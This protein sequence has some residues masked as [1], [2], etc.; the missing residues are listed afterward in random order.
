MKNVYRL[1]FCLL[2][3]GPIPGIVKAQKCLLKGTIFS[4]DSLPLANA[5][6][7]L[8]NLTGTVYAFAISGQDGRFTIEAT[9]EKPGDYLLMVSH[10]SFQAVEKKILLDANSTAM[11][12]FHFALSPANSELKEVIVKTK[13]P[14]ISVKYDT[15]E[16]DATP[17][18]G[19]EIIKTADL[20][21]NMPGFLVDNKGRISYNGKEV[22]KILI[23]GDDL[24]GDNY[25]LISTNLQAGVIGKVQVLENYENNRLLKGITKSGK[26]AINLKIM[27]QF[28]NTI[29]GNMEAGGSLNKRFITNERL[30]YISPKIKT[31]LFSNANNTGESPEANVQFYYDQDGPAGSQHSELENRQGLVNSGS[32]TVPGLDDKYSKDNNDISSDLMNS[33][34][35]AKSMKIRT[36]FGYS[37]HRLAME[38]QLVNETSLPFMPPWSIATAETVR[39]HTGEWIAQTSLDHDN[40]GGNTGS[41]FISFSGRKDLNN[42]KNIS[43]LAIVDTLTERLHNSIRNFQFSGNETFR[44]RKNNI[45]TAELAISRQSIVQDFMSMTY[46]FVDYFST[47]SLFSL[48]KQQSNRLSGKYNAGLKW[49]GKKG[50]LNYIYGVTLQLRNGNSLN[51]IANTKRDNF[52]DTMVTRPI[53]FE[54]YQLSKYNLYAN[55]Q[56][57]ICKRGLLTTNISTGYGSE[58]ILD[59]QI[60]RS[61]RSFLFQSLVEVNYKLSTFRSLIA[62]YR[63]GNFMP[64]PLNFYGRGILSGNATILDGAM[65][66]RRGK[67]NDLS[68]S[69]LSNNLFGGSRLIVS[70]LFNSSSGDYNTGYFFTPE[71]VKTN[72]NPTN[73]NF[74]TAGN[75]DAEKYFAAIRGN[76]FLSVQ[77]AWY[78]T[79]NRVN[80]SLQTNLSSSLRMQLKFASSFNFPVNVETSVTSM[81]VGNSAYTS[82]IKYAK[83]EMWQYEGYAK[84]KMKFSRSIYSNLLYCLYGFKPNSTCRTLDAF[85]AFRITKT[86]SISM[87]VH[88]LLNDKILRQR[89]IT[90]NNISES[91]FFLVERY[92]LVRVGFDF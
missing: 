91:S 46:R 77:A 41:Y 3:F 23:D 71:F 80:D 68:I 15:I 82:G 89:D 28:K 25:K 73:H 62:N 90:A 65:D 34:R 32:I 29:S 49:I 42:Y 9:I 6:I 69:Y 66:L 40:M 4:T 83:H 84:L 61:F 1:L 18:K 21:R 72:I 11:A 22:Q 88:N 47:D 54:N 53:A 7:V 26:I 85:G 35:I 39:Q 43:S 74:Y 17:F 52:T 63:I 58:N 81:F 37:V 16:I 24:T 57:R 5:S 75:V 30:I 86:W 33:F 12:E 64:D 67:S 19:P 78:K 92:I 20:L 48:N 14:S 8:K 50:K 44:L 60:P 38:D 31:L 55:A 87:T 10:I 70:G 36:R 59:L 51:N 45:L 76:I 13:L 2:V 79:H 56:T 27:E